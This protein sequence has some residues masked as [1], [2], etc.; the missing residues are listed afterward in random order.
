MREWLPFVPSRT[1][2]LSQVDGSESGRCFSSLQPLVILSPPTDFCFEAVRPPARPGS[3]APG[4]TM[5]LGA[6]CVSYMNDT[7]TCRLCEG[8]EVCVGEREVR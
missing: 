2:L 5:H 4:G 6:G 7:H 3:R 8:R 1:C